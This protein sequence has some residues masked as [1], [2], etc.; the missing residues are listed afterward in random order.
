MN[1]VQIRL[2]EWAQ[3]NAL[4]RVSADRD[5]KVAVNNCLV[6]S[7]VPSH[8]FRMLQRG[9]FESE[10]ELKSL[11]KRKSLAMVVPPKKSLNFEVRSKLF[12]AFY[13]TER[14]KTAS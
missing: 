9:Q 2:N 13:C 3:P 4:T 10:R 11:N 6:M 5:P 7:D 12:K 1:K 8:E 14:E